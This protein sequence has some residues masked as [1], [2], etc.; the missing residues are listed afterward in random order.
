MMWHVKQPDKTCTK[1][2]FKNLQV[3]QNGILENVHVSHKRAEKKKQRNE[4]QNK[5][6]IKMVNLSTN[7]S[8]YKFN[9]NSLKT[10]VKRQQLTIDWKVCPTYLLSKK[11]LN[12]P[13]FKYNDI[14]RLK[15]KKLKK[16]YNTNINQ[17]K[18]KVAV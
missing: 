18:A 13:H 3:N 12:R 9:V 2:T 11:S 16:I 17:R 7:I 14:G 8:I 10:P 1:S 6:K 4:K 5:Q 15:V